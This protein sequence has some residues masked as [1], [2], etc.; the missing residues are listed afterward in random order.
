MIAQTV[1]KKIPLPFH[2]ELDRHKLFPIRDQRF[3]PWLTREGNDGVQ[4][5]GHEQAEAAMPGPVFVIVRHRGEHAVANTGLAKLISCSA[6]CQR[7]RRS[8]INQQS[9]ASVKPCVCHPVGLPDADVNEITNAGRNDKRPINYWRPWLFDAVLVSAGVLFF[10]AVQYGTYE[11]FGVACLMALLP[12]IPV[13]VLVGGAGSTVFALSK[14]W[15]EKHSLKLPMALALLVGPALVLTLLLVLLGAGQSSGHR[16]AYIC[17]GN[18]PASASHVQVTGYS[19]FL[20]EEWLAVF[21]SGPK[22]F[23]T[24]VAQA[25]LAP[26][27]EFEF[28]NT[29]ETSA[30]KKCRLFQKVP[31][32]NDLPCFKRVFKEG[33]EHQRGSVYAVFDPATSTA[34]IFREYHD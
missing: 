13:L 8:Q 11:F 16:L 15:I 25:K 32:P 23:Q 22:D 17:L 5:I 1:I 26:T 18:A 4:M 7:L 28:R 33:E 12:F 19:T 21:N 34:V 29:L 2:P 6:L 9:L 27:D 20:R 24:L 14:V 10:L 31:Q 3:H 30:L